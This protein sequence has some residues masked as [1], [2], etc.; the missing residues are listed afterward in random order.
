MA[1]PSRK[2]FYFYFKFKCHACRLFMLEKKASRS[3][4]DVVGAGV[5]PSESGSPSPEAFSHSVQLSLIAPSLP[6][7][8]LAPGGIP[9]LWV[10]LTNLQLCFVIILLARFHWP[11]GRDA[12]L[13]P[14]PQR[15]TCPSC[16]GACPQMPSAMGCSPPWQL[17][18]FPWLFYWWL[19]CALSDLWTEVL[20]CGGGGL[21][22]KSHSNE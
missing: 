6:E 1:I 14:S 19:F 15:E 2:L 3:W 18:F 13:G 7:N 5:P 12:H 21:C 17:H 22:I 9:W 11:S 16:A 10:V 20:G 8:F 4:R